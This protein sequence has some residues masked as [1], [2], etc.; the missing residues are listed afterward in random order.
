MAA[1]MAVPPEARERAVALLHDAQ[2]HPDAAAKLDSLRELRELALH[3]EPRLLPELLPVLLELRND[4]AS[5]IRN[6]LVEIIEEVGLRQVEYVPVMMPVLLTL[7]RG[8]PAFAR[9]AITAGTNLFRHTLEYVLLKGIYTRQVDKFMQD[10]WISVLQFKEFVYPFAQQHGNDGVRL[11]AVKFIETVILLFTPDPSGPSQPPLPDRLD[12]TSKGINV[13]WIVSGHPLLDATAMG[14]E[15]SKSLGLLLN[16]LRQPDVSA[17]PGPVAI[18]IVN[19]LAAIAKRRPSFYGR[20]L[21]VLLSL[22]PSCEAIKGGQVASVVTALKN[23]FVQLLKCTYPAAAPWR[24]RLTSALRQMNAGDVADLAVE[25]SSRGG[26]RESRESSSRSN[27]VKEER[28]D[29]RNKRPPPQE[30]GNDEESYGKRLRTTP[31]PPVQQHFHPDA[32]GYANGAGLPPIQQMIQ[33][34]EALAAKGEIASIDLL[35]SRLPPDT[36]ADV[37]IVNMQNLP[38]SVPADFMDKP[39][40]LPPPPPP[41][42]IEPVAMDGRRDPRRDP[43]RMDPRMDPRRLP[44]PGPP[45]VM[46]KQEDLQ[47]PGVPP[48]F[49]TVKAEPVSPP[50]MNSRDPRASLKATSVKMEPTFTHVKSEPDEDMGIRTISTMYGALYPSSD[51][52]DDRQEA[53]TSGAGLSSFLPVVTLS[54]EQRATLGNSAL[55]RILEGSKSVSAA[56]GGGLRIA[57][58]ARLTAQSAEALNTLQK[59]ILADYANHMGHELALHVFYELYL[60]HIAGGDSIEKYENFFVSLSQGLKDSLPPSDKS[61]SKL[62]CE[63]PLF[64]EGAFALLESLCNPINE[65]NG[66]R[67]TQGLSALWSLILQRPAVRERCLNMALE[68]AVHEVDDARTKAIRLVANKLYPVTFISQKIEE[69]ATKM[70]LSVVNVGGHNVDSEAQERSTLQEV[71]PGDQEANAADGGGTKAEAQRCMSLY[72]ALCTKKHALLGELFNVYDRA[73]KP[74]KQAIHRQIPV[75]VRTVGQS[76][77]ELLSIISAPPQGCEN[78]LLQVLHVLTEGTTPSP[79]LIKTIKQL[80]ETRIKDAVFL[81][82]ILSSLSK[83]EVLP[84]FPRLVDLPPDKFQVALARILQGSAHTGPALTPAEVLIALHGIDQQRDAV[85][86]KKVTEACSACLQ[87]RNVFNQDV[88]AKVLNQLVEQTPLPK[89]FMR[90]VIQ[91]VGTFRSLV[92]FVMDILLRLVNKQ[93]WKTPQLWVGFLKCASETT[94]HS[95]RVLLQLPTAQLENALVKHPTLKTPL[96]AHASQPSVRSSVPR[97]SLVLLGVIQDDVTAV[98]AASAPSSSGNAPQQ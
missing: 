1:M 11:H 10:S 81:I 30:N 20:I 18:V 17:L 33:M 74:V 52:L 75:L 6:F 92:G 45:M 77:P 56:G 7:L 38:P 2:L 29:P 69:F 9:R 96:A 8:E 90:T 32:S 87:Q 31:P 66:D 58:L 76:S 36:L 13:S 54:N 95:F 60:M 28:Q 65:P 89:L 37:V 70:L 15:A 43:R 98:E 35:M 80:H 64:P 88:L 72:F 93:I 46:P 63:I 51:A 41:P 39:Q 79:E 40:L 57:L 3:R 73:P 4:R 27:R 97:S 34:F 86:L 61:L 12:G 5:A 44:S 23:A 78:L 22:G 14:Q 55:T 62:L 59:H 71:A 48:V 50:V 53:G 84:I 19:S 49:R 42:P 16:Q 85:P 21:P 47:Q 24:D 67:V 94:P 82:P 26:E 68:C 25:R 83:E 91:A